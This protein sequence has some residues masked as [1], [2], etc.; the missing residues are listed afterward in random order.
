VGLFKMG[1]VPVLK[2]ESHDI[3]KFCL[4]NYDV[5]VAGIAVYTVNIHSG[6]LY[7]D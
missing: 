1:L 7:G 4:S 5:H 6:N 2:D 3:Q